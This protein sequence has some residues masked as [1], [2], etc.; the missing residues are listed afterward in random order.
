MGSVS[1][2]TP[3]QV[4]RKA[5]DLIERRGLWKAGRDDTWPLDTDP[6]CVCTAI[7]SITGSD[8][9]AYRQGIESMRLHLGLRVQGG[10]EVPAWNDAPERT[11]EE[12]VREMRACAAKLEKETA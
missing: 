1:T 3:A 10:G 7:D 2:L 11:A 4:L 12:V 9:I 8:R 5:A 6:H